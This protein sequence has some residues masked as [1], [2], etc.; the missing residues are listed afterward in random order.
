MERSREAGRGRE[1]DEK[2]RGM[3]RETETE[4]WREGGIFCR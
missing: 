3:E 4:R 1:G 2:G